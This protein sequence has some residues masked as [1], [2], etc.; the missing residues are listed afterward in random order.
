MKVKILRT[1]K[2]SM[3]KETLTVL[4]ASLCLSFAS[5]RQAVAQSGRAA[6]TKKEVRTAGA[7]RP[8]ADTAR[9]VVGERA[10]LADK[11]EIKKR[12]SSEKKK[13]N[14]ELRE[15]LEQE[16][17]E[18]PAADVYGEDSWSGNVNPFAGKQAVSVPAKY[19][20]DL[21]EFVMPLKR[22]HVTSHYGYRRSFGRMHYG[23]DLAL[24]VGDTVRAAFSG[25]V[26]ISSYEG[27]GYGNY[28][29]IRHPNGLE[30]VYGHL[31]RSMVRE[32]MIVKAGQPIALGGNTGRSTGP[33]LHFEARFM[34]HCIN[35][36]ELFDFEEGVPRLDVYTFRK[37]SASPARQ[38]ASR[39]SDRVARPAKQV[40]NIRTHRIK[41]GETLYSIAKQYGTTVSKLRSANGLSAKTAP[42][43]G[44]SLRV[45]N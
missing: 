41:K 45:P 20:I 5:P 24:S 27:R 43:P 1:I 28:V 12:I 40:S 18:F 39:Q 11:L 44:A 21:N 9:I 10:L 17:L 2:A 31:H 16:S 26:R 14:E 36:E 25:K 22:K 23:T 37:S 32:G 34:G 30:T 7:E 3:T 13:R 33:H 15:E 35:P 19:D 42:K 38:L 29:V 4:C 8:L 6:S